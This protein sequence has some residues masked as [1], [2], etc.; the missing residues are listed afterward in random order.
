MATTVT[1]RNTARNNRPCGH[2]SVP[3]GRNNVTPINSTVA[4]S[5]TKAW[6]SSPRETTDINSSPFRQELHDVCR[7]PATVITTSD[8]WPALESRYAGPVQDTRKKAG[9]GRKLFPFVNPVH[10]Q[11]EIWRAGMLVEHAIYLDTP[12]ALP[13]APLRVHLARSKVRNS[14]RYRPASDHFR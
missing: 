7:H 9:R 12:S 2:R 8:V 14:P 6:R 11:R 10:P 4:A 13:E 1:N 3:A 5:E